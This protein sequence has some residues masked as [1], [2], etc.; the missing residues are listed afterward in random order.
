[1]WLTPKRLL[2][3]GSST[4]LPLNCRTAHKIT[5]NASLMFYIRRNALMHQ[6]PNLSEMARGH[7][8]NELTCAACMCLIMSLKVQNQREFEG[9][10]PSSNCTVCSKNSAL[11]L[12]MK[13][14]K[15]F[16]GQYF[17]KIA[18]KYLWHITVHH[19]YKIEKSAAATGFAFVRITMVS[20]I[21]K[22]RKTTLVVFI[23]NYD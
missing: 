5:T 8:V 18:C 4:F 10:T 1:M 13:K 14:V 12:W 11:Q 23:M 2:I 16:L 9:G 3:S 21:K 17:W 22:V 20:L 6:E 15:L 7:W 19:V